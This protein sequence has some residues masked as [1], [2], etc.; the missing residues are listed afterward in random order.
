MRARRRPAR[1]NEELLAASRRTI[2]D[3]RARRAHIGHARAELVRAVARAQEALDK[4]RA[5]L[6]KIDALL[7]R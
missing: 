6:A 5:L 4:S 7:S 2:A 1:S 3:F